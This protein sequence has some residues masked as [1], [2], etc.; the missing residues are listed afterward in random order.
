MSIVVPFELKMLIDVIMI[1]LL[2]QIIR[3]LILYF[4]SSDEPFE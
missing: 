4:L 2:T 3:K 1:Q